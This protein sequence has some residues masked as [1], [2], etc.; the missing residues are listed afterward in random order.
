[1]ISRNPLTIKEVKKKIEHY[2]AYQERSHLEVRKKL[3][4]YNISSGELE[5]IITELIL[6]GFL[7]EAR[8]AETFSSGKFRLKKWGKIKI[9]NGL[10]R[11][12]VSPACIKKGLDSLNP[13]EY[14]KTLMELLEK[15]KSTFEQ[16]IPD[17][18]V[19]KKLADFVIQKGYEPEL[20][21]ESIKFH[22]E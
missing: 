8:F 7:N 11:K 6:S 18:L 10:L 5:E 21:W 13:D 17:P 2:C 15:K 20:V 9:K 4:G 3:Q 12:G 14:K 16:K 19:Q 1:M 22:P